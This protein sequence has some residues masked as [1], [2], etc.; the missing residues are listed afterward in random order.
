MGAWRWYPTNTTLKDGR[1]LVTA[2]YQH[3][4]HRMF[5]GR[6][7]GSAPASPSADTVRRW[8]PVEG[9]AWD[10][11]VQPEP[12]SPPN[13]PRPDPREGHTGTD[14]TAITGFGNQTLFFGGKDQ[15]GGALGDLWALKRED[16]PTGADY[17]YVWEHKTPSGTGPLARSEHTAIVA[18]E[19][20]IVFG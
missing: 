19:A 16:N 20:V 18:R 4:Q 14:L 9:G 3:H 12:D 5:G 11:P 8:A 17:R 10:P 13:P 7:G 15:F 6:L 2:G 1:V